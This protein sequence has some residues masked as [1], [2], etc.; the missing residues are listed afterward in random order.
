MDYIWVIKPYTNI[1]KGVH[2]FMSEPSLCGTGHLLLVQ[3][4]RS[5]ESANAVEVKAAARFLPRYVDMSNHSVSK[6]F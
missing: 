3:L 4:L 5:I 2:H 6:L 1:K